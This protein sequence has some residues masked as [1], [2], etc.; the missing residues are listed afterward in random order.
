MTS[1]VIQ[2]AARIILAVMLLGA[3]VLG[4]INHGTWAPRRIVDGRHVAVFVA[5]EGLLIGLAGGW[6][7]W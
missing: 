2:L 4:V 1:E 6:G 7:T 3:V 5:L